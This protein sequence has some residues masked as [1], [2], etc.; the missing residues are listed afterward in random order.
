MAVLVRE[1]VD[2]L[3]AEDD[4]LEATFDALPEIANWVPSRT[5]W[6]RRSQ[7]AG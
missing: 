2:L 3:L 4:G 5:E 1:A 6:E 7:P